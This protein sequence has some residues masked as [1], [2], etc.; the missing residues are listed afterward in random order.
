MSLNT[1]NH[2][3]KTSTLEV[4]FFFSKFV[5]SILFSGCK[6]LGFFSRFR[7][8]GGVPSITKAVISSSFFSCYFDGVRGKVANIFFT[9]A[10]ILTVL[11]VDTI[12]YASTWCKVR[13]GEKRLLDTTKRH[14]GRMESVTTASRR[15]A[16]NMSLFLL[17]FVVQWW[18]LALFGVWSHPC[19]YAS[20]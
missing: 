20:Q 19:A 3:S 5:S 6:Y 16:R 10:P 15:V 14:Y 13:S 18:S 8:A 9:T 4:D 12:L 7:T 11:V 1:D 17:A 2:C